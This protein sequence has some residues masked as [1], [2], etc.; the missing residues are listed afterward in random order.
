MAAWLG[1]LCRAGQGRLAGLSLIGWPLPCGR[2]PAGELRQLASWA[3]EVPDAGLALLALRRAR[4]V[5]LDMHRR[6]AS[7][8]GGQ[9]CL[10]ACRPARPCPKAHC[11][12]AAAGL[13]LPS[14]RCPTVPALCSHPPLCRRRTAAGAGAASSSSPAGRWSATSA[15]SI[16][17]ICWGRWTAPWPGSRQR[18]PPSRPAS[19]GR[20]RRQRGRRQ[21]PIG[22]AA[23]RRRL[24]QQQRRGRASVLAAAAAGWRLAF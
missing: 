9:A 19:R 8:V 22:G 20:R 14:L 24:W 13:T 17:R 6:A 4:P 16:W 18:S 7:E 12:A 10:P 5:L 23:R 21:G 3:G 11:A 1:A 2:R 15:G